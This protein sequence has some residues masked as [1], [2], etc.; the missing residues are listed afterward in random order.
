MIRYVPIRILVKLPSIQMSSINFRG[1]IYQ[2]KSSP[3]LRDLSIAFKIGGS[4]A[5]KE[6][7]TTVSRYY[8]YT[9]ITASAIV[10]DPTKD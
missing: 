5:W 10:K 6:L 4:P 8:Q 3:G 2:Y 9:E 7:R 1:K